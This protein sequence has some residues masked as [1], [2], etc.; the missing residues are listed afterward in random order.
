MCAFL[1]RCSHLLE[2]VPLARTLRVDLNKCCVLF[3]HTVDCIMWHVCRLTAQVNLQTCSNC[4][5]SA[6][7][8][9]ANFS[10]PSILGQTK[11]D[12]CVYLTEQ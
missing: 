6:K 9:Q 7:K 10:K 1:C 8:E 11:A 5:Y 4:I 3:Q 2:L 12:W